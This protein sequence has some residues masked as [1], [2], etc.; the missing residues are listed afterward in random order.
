MY[1]IFLQ[2]LNKYFII[3]AFIVLF[4]GAAFAQ[5]EPLKELTDLTKGI[6]YVKE[7]PPKTLT[8]E[9]L[10]HFGIIH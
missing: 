2:N 4:A 1:R 8:L 6:I 5:Y 7:K 3:G 9:D 10:Y